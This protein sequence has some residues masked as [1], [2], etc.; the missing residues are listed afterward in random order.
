MRCLNP[1]TIASLSVALHTVHMVPRTSSYFQAHT[2]VLVESGGFGDTV[3]AFHFSCEERALELHERHDRYEDEEAAI[4]RIL[5]Q[6]ITAILQ[7]HECN[8]ER[9]TTIIISKAMK[10]CQM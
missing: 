6:F 1:D 7:V 5:R 8:P 9:P 3:Y 4:A 10:K 2:V